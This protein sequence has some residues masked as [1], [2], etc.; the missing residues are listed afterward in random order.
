[1]EDLQDMFIVHTIEEIEV[2]GGGGVLQQQ[3]RRGA[4][5][6]SAFPALTSPQG[7]SGPF[8][9]RGLQDPGELQGVGGR[10]WNQLAPP[11]CCSPPPPQPGSPLRQGLIA[12]HDQFK[13]TLPD[14]DKE[15][16]AI[17]GV[18]R[19]AQ[20]IA[21]LHSIKLSGN[22]PYT[23]VTPQVI[24]S[25]WERVR[26]TPPP[27]P[28]ASA[29]PPRHPKR[30][31][32]GKN[33]AGVS[34]GA[35]AGPGA[36]VGFRAAPFRAPREGGGG[37]GRRQGGFIPRP[38]F[39]IAAPLPPAGPAAGAE[40]GPR[41]AG[42]AE[43]AAIQRAPAPAVRQPGQHHGALDPDQDGGEGERG[44]VRP[45]GATPE[46]GRHPGELPREPPCARGSKTKKR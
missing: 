43:Q 18:Q 33:G 34:D 41:A 7:A 30:T 10:S 24:N 6:L 29:P 40:A 22:N 4:P 37:E 5:A 46:P 26:A 45:R 28:P 31:P 32:A 19:E 27:R 21:D 8:V 13:S 39:S 42:R 17:L 23:S 3:G 38:G 16:E 12:A 15:R 20:R 36:P 44:G 14:A 1:M 35:G 11:E 2:G 25:K 9:L